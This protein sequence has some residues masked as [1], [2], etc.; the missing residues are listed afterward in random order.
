MVE[1][2]FTKAKNAVNAIMKNMM[3]FAVSSI[4][5][6][7]IGFGIMFGTSNGLFGTDGFFLHDYA[8]SRDSW[9]FA[10]W[11]YQLV[12]V[13]STAA[14]VSGAM[15]ERTRFFASLMFTVF[16]SAFIYP[17][18][19]SWVWGS[20]Y[21]GG[22]WLENLG[23]KDFAGSTVIH[24]IG[25]WAGLAGTMVLGPRMG[26]F[27]RDGTINP[28][29]GHNLPLAALG[30]L[31]LWFGWYGFNAGNT[32][33]GG[34]K[35]ANIMINTTLSGSAAAVSG[36]I[37]A[38]FRFGKPD[39]GMTLNGALSGLVAITAGCADVEPVWA[40]VTGIVAG[41]IVVFSVIQFDRLK[42]DDPVGA[43]S[44]HGVCGV[45]GT[46]ALGMFKTGEMFN[47][48]NIGIQLLGSVV[49]FVWAF[50]VSYGIFMFIK[51]AIGLRVTEEEEYQGLDYSEHTAAAYP[52]FQ[53][54]NIK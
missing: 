5:F 16:M 18:F 6:W 29:L 3:D 20:F 11:M 53:I 34:S 51:K 14:I 23:F 15:A 47:L 8:D 40:V 49:A 32:L 21:H 12:F 48:H 52:D 46:V 2:G 31:I 33:E 10:F 19:G 42:I 44:V 25:G 43:V 54:T 27:R 41:I 36:M 26:K 38:W 17:I 28:I 50:F 22:G 39:V 1:I 30:T 4:A 24:A 13:S 37:T 45:W 9:L 7:V 35:I